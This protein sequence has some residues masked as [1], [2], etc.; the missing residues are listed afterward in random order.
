[1]TLVI[2]NVKE[3]FLSSV[4]QFVSSIN[5]EVCEIIKDDLTSWN[6]IEQPTPEDIEWAQNLLDSK[7][8]KAVSKIS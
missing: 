7:G 2:R 5:A 4:E 1:M 6:D 8:I 3:E